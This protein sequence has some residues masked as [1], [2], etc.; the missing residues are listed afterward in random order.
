MHASWR[1]WP[2]GSLEQEA[3]HGMSKGPGEDRAP[4]VGEM[5]PQGPD[6][7]PRLHALTSLSL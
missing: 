7:P 6:V 4:L 3:T 5:A 2:P 1:W